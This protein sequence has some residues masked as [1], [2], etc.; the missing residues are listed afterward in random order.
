MPSRWYRSLSTAFAVQEELASTGLPEVLSSFAVPGTYDD[1]AASLAVE[2]TSDG[3][4]GSIEALSRDLAVD[5]TVVD[6]IPPTSSDGPSIAESYQVADLDRTAV[7]GGVACRSEESVGTLAP[8]LYDERERE[9]FF[10]TSNHLFRGIDGERAP[11]SLFREN[12]T[13]RIGRVDRAYPAADI[14]RIEPTGGYHPVPEIA[15]GSPGTVIGQY[16]KAGLADLMARG[17]RLRKIGAFSDRTGGEIEGI[18]GVTCY[19]GEVCKR[20]QLKWGDESTMVDGDSGSVNYH[21]DPENPDEYVLVGGLN[22]ARTWWPGA[23]FTWGTA[24]HHLLDEY[25]LHF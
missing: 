4:R 22:N 7:P 19:S 10:A 21:R 8:A 13:R 5:L 3:V 2:A 15:R 20:G 25:G 11:V 12:E 23:D 14:A 6:G 16:T 18:D 1:P 9:A 17:E 24:A